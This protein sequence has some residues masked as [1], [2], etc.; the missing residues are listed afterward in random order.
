MRNSHVLSKGVW[1]QGAIVG[2]RRGRSLR[3]S[4]IAREWCNGGADRAQFRREVGC[5][6]HFAP[7]AK[8]RLWDLRTD[9]EPKLA[10]EVPFGATVMESSFS[11]DH[12]WVAFGAWDASVKVPELRNAGSPKPEQFSG[13]AGRILSV[14]FIP[15][16]RFLVISGED[17]TV[18]VWDPE[19]PRQAPVTLRVH[20]GRCGW[21]AFR[22]TAVYWSP[23]A[24]TRRSRCGTSGCPISSPSRAALPADSSLTRRSPTLSET[25]KQAGPA[26]TSRKRSAMSVVDRR[27]PKGFGTAGRR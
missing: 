15:D 22:L 17:R 11:R 20:K 7:D 9:A 16:S 13:H 14:A 2:S 19:E 26:S 27:L 1:G 10:A 8:G 18:R 24:P 23:A 5:D 21:S 12:R 6:R 25:C 3:E 4:A